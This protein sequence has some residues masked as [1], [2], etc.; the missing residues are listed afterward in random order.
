MRGIFS[1]KVLYAN[2]SKRV[3]TAAEKAMRWALAKSAYRIMADA[4]STIKRSDKPSAPGTPPHTSRGALRAS[5][6]YAVDYTI[7][8]AV[9]GPMG[10]VIAGIG[11]LHE[12]GGTYKGHEYP[13]RAFMGPS[14]DREL[15]K[16]AGEFSG[17]IGQ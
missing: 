4:K 11:E 1:A 8:E 13:S 3:W 9:I 7:P 16:F 6:R 5:I 15:D 17:S 12:L 10:S 14:L 2:Q